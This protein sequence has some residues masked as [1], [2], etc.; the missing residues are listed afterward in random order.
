M[1]LRPPALRHT[2]HF[3]HVGGRRG[4]LRRMRDGKADLALVDELGGGSHGIYGRACHNRDGKQYPEVHNPSPLEA[5]QPR[6]CDRSEAIQG[7]R[8]STR[9]NS[10]HYCAYRMTSS[11]RKKKTIKL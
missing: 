9:L 10:S 3:P 2:K 6:H 5:T 4:D 7:D 8:K 1:L 11:A